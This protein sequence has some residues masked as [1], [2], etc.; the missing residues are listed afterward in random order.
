MLRR[1]AAAFLHALGAVF[2]LL[3]IADA[4][5]VQALAW[6]W[7][8]TVLLPAVL[9]IGFTAADAFLRSNVLRVFDVR[10]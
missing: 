4:W 6:L 8:A 1:S 3:A 2:T 7:A 5:S 9:E 10:V